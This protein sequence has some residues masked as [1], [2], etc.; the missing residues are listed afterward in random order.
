LQNYPELANKRRDFLDRQIVGITHQQADKDFKIAEFYERTGHP[1]SAFFYFEMIKRRYPGSTYA[2][3]AT[4]RA[5]H[6]REK[7]ELQEELEET[8]SRGRHSKQGL[9]RALQS[10]GI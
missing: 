1:G 3:R 10:K 6:L 4:A 5:I 2:E 8:L 9:W 7:H